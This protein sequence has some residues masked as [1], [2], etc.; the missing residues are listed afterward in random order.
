M[1]KNK[2]INN[3]HNKHCFDRFLLHEMYFKELNNLQKDT[4][5]HFFAYREILRDH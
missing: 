4:A 2:Y 1:K 3:N 5:L